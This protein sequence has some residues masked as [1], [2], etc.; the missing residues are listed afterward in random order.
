MREITERGRERES[1]SLVVLFGMVLTPLTRCLCVRDK[2]SVCVCVRER[3][4]ERETI[5]C[6]AVFW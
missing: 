5:T 4:K 6:G 3:E 2:E 1:L